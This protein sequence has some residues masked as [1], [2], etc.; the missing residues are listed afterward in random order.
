[1]RRSWFP[2]CLLLAALAVLGR[3]IA[4]D[5]RFFFRL[6][7]VPNHDMYQGSAFFATSMHSLAT[8]GDIAW[9][10]PIARNGNAQYFQAF[11]SPLAPTPH[12]LAFI[13]WAQAIRVLS[14]LGVHLPEYY[15]YLVMTYVVLPFLAF[16]AFGA[17]ASVLF[18][19]RAAVALILIVGCFSS[20]GLWNGAWFYFQEDTS[21]FFLLAATIA[22][23]RKPSWRRLS[24]FLLSV[25][26]QATS[27][28]YWT[29]YN[30]FFIVIFLGSYALAYQRP[31]RRL[32]TR[33][34]TRSAATKGQ[35]RYA[36]R[37]GLAGLG[38]LFVATA[39]VWT[40]IIGSIVVE[41][42]GAYTRNMPGGVYTLDQASHA[43]QPLRYQILEPFDPEIDRVLQQYPISNPMHNARYIGAALAPFLVLLPCW[44]WQRRDRW[45]ITAALGS[46]AV[47]FGPPLIMGLW[48][49][50]PFM[51]GIVHIFSLYSRYWHLMLA[52]VATAVFERIVGVVDRA[53]VGRMLKVVSGLAIAASGVLA[54]AW[55][56]SGRYRAGDVNLQAVVRASF[57]V[58][59]PSVLLVQRFLFDGATTRRMLAAG[60]LVL[61]F[62][63]LTRYFVDA[64]VRDMEFTETRWVKFP[65][66]SDIQAKLRVPWATP[67]LNSGF[68][69]NLAGNMPVPNT[70]WP[71][72]TYLRQH[73]LDD[74]P[75]PS[76]N[77]IRDT[78]L[79][80]PPLEF[81]TRAE[82]GLLS[83]ASRPGGAAGDRPG[84]RVLWLSG[85]P[86]TPNAAGP[87][88][89]APAARSGP[90]DRAF[91]AAWR[92]WSYNG[93]RFDVNAPEAGFVLVRQLADPLW[94]IEVDSQPVKVLQADLVALAIPIES[95]RHDVR[96]SYWPLARRLY[97]PASMMLEATW[98]AV[99]VTVLRRPSTRRQEAA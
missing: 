19:R 55:A 8:S 50:L 59:I 44:R 41:Q 99:I 40:V 52:L 56:F 77:A 35:G 86:V 20:I 84:S 98:L 24:V 51:N 3:L 60:V 6:Q 68:A 79:T 82:I 93:F 95:G 89:H 76:L 70:F 4:F 45:F 69:S 71:A 10:S 17:L 92:E 49:V 36:V 26:N 63:D 31:L 18:R 7:A 61:A 72:N 1:M 14:R 78:G 30:T 62:V 9:W 87:E 37:I 54:L 25:L 58:L 42:A 12:H 33:V 85:P 29:L 32:L 64:S 46:L 91:R 94:R 96:M 38:S 67:D 74:L 28:N 16:L 83:T 53:A 75:A 5:Y 11:L 48:A 23:S 57:F 21:L 34:G 22:F 47:C 88:S 2:F 81:F 13:V 90:G 66:A 43:V 97:W 73:S 27:V 65:L 80:G 15:Q 39:V